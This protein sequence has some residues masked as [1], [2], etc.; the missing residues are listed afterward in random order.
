MH[1]HVSDVLCMLVAVSLQLPESSVNCTQLLS[2]Q[3]G[4][5]VCTY[6]KTT[7]LMDHWESVEDRIDIAM[8]AINLDVLFQ[9]Y[10]RHCSVL[11][12]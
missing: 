11:V 3:I 4:A 5:V 8:A 12:L 7:A 10:R 6:K 9:R 2:N 1:L